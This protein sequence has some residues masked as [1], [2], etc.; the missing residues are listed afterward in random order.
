MIQRA[1][2]KKIFIKPLGFLLLFFILLNNTNSFSQT[3]LSASKNIEWQKCL[4][5]SK[6]DSAN[7]VLLNNDGTIIVVGSSQSND[8]DVSGH[9]GTLDTADAWIA[10]LD[11]SGK[12]LSY[13]NFAEGWLQPNGKVLGRPVD[14]QVVKDG[15]LLVSDDY[16]GVI[17]RIVYKK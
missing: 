13:S 9:H 14:V 7:D 1:F 12:S 3:P 2:M 10:K 8:G 5:G 15:S 6:N 17:Y 4:G 11:A 16:S